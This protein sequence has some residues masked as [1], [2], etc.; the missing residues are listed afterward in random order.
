MKIV[1][2][3]INDIIPYDKNPRNNES[4]VAPTKASI[5]AFGFQQPIVIDKNNVIVCGHT[6]YLAAKELGLEKVPCKIADDLTDDEIKAY[7][8][9]D[10]KTAEFA[11]WDF[12]L[13][14]SEIEDIDIDMSEFGFDDWEDIEAEEY[15]VD[16]KYTKK[17]EIP[18]Y[19]ITGENPDIEELV[20]DAKVNELIR[21]IEN[22]NLKSEAKHFL[23]MAAYRH[24]VFNYSKI[25]EWY[26]HQDAVT[27]KLIEDSALVLIDYDDAI[28]KGYVVLSSRLEEMMSD[29]E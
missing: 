4:A 2:V 6:R 15:E 12:E 25:A 3:N 16:D 29:A 26:A 10:N 21:D 9:A 19:E 28:K 24:L 14:N 17:R 22:S 20:D 1:D 11:T 18:Q 5:E 13:L 23:K 8:L 7:R 27:Q